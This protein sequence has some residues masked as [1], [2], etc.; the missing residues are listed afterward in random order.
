MKVRPGPSRA[1]QDAKRRETPKPQRLSCAGPQPRPAKAAPAGRQ[2]AQ[3]HRRQAAREHGFQA[4][5]KKEV[6]DQRG[7]V[8]GLKGKNIGATSVQMMASSTV[9]GAP[10]RA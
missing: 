1:S 5:D 2:A 7:H 3:G 4:A 6:T 9:S 10:S 8:H